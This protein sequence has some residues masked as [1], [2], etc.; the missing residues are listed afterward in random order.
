LYL[1]FIVVAIMGIHVHSNA[2]Q[3]HFEL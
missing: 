2:D 1:T 3:R